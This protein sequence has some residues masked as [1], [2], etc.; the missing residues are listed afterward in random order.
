M[1]AEMY[2]FKVKCERPRRKKWRRKV[3]RVSRETGAVES[4]LE[5][6]KAEKVLHL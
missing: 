4:P 6:A 1:I 2:T 5:A 3:R